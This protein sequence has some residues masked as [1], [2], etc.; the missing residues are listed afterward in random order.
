[1]HQEHAFQE[2][3]MD[4]LKHR[5]VEAGFASPAHLGRFL[6][7]MVSNKSLELQCHHV[8]TET[9]SLS[10]GEPITAAAAGTG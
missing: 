10:R 7:A 9:R 2:V 6:A 5:R 8:T 3:W 1:V 4:F